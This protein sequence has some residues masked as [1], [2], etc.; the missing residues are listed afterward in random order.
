[1]QCFNIGTLLFDFKI[2]SWTMVKNGTPWQKYG[3]KFIAQL[4]IWF[5]SVTQTG[6]WAKIIN[7]SMRDKN[8]QAGRCDLCRTVVVDTSVNHS[9]STRPRSQFYSDNIGKL[10]FTVQLKDNSRILVCRQGKSIKK[11]V[12]TVLVS[13]WSVMSL[14]SAWPFL[15]N[16]TIVSQHTGWLIHQTPNIMEAIS[17]C[18][19]QKL[20]LEFIQTNHLW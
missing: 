14:S 10:F 11:S 13:E 12:G 6:K 7:H 9:D 15:Q 1:M 4:Q 16:R 20:M 5:L 18:N 2:T 17:L 19:S 8:K 3:H